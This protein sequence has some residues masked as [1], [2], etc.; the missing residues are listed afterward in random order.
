MSRTPMAREKRTEDPRRSG[1]GAGG[2]RRSGSAAPGAARPGLTSRAAILAVVVC[3][4]ALSLA[5]PVREYIAQRQEI[6]EQRQQQRTAQRKVAEL[7]EHRARLTDESYIKR[8]ARRR[9]NYCMPDEKCYL[10]LDGDGSQREQTAAAQSAPRPPWYQ[11]LWRSVEEA[12]RP[13]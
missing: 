13:R 4:I 3:A 11:A 1:N 9:L 10:V 5:Y 12:D 6:A 2:S 8:E 7:E